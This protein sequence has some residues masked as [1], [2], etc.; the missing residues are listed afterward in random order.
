MMMKTKRKFDAFGKRE[1]RSAGPFVVFGNTNRR[2][3]IPPRSIPAGSIRI[4]PLLN[5]SRNSNVL[6]VNIRKCSSLRRKNISRCVAEPQLWPSWNFTSP[7]TSMSNHSCAPSVAGERIFVGIFRYEWS[8]GGRTLEK[9]SLFASATRRNGIRT[10]VS[11]CFNYLTRKLNKRSMPTWKNAA[12]R[13]NS[14]VDSIRNV[15]INARCVNSVPITR[16]SS[17]SISLA[18]IR[19]SR[20]RK[21]SF[22]KASRPNPTRCPRRATGTATRSFWSNLRWAL[23]ISTI[24]PKPKWKHRHFTIGRVWSSPMEVLFFLIQR[25]LSIR[26]S[27][28]MR[29]SIRTD[30]SIVRCAI[31]VI[32][33]D[34]T[35]SVITRR[36]TKRPRTKRRSAC[37]WVRNRSNVETRNSIGISAISNTCPSWMDWYPRPC[38]AHTTPRDWNRNERSKESTHPAKEPTT[39]TTTKLSIESMESTSGLPKHGQWIWPRTKLPLCWWSN[40]NDPTALRSRFMSSNPTTPW[41]SSTKT[42]R[43]RAKKSH[44]PFPSTW[45]NQSCERRVVSSRTAVRTVSTE[46]TGARIRCDTSEH[47][48]KSNRTRM[49]NTSWVAKKPNGPMRST[50]GPSVSLFQRKS[51]D[52]SPTFD[53][54]NG[55]ICKNPSGR[56]SKT[57]KVTNRSFSSAFDPMITSQHRPRH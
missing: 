3:T 48:T 28:R 23:I 51:W 10:W 22:T 38:P 11:K 53:I 30:C 17:N 18:I 39:T 33:G 27:R 54:F 24:R 2:S 50:N 16:N 9:S 40:H 7:R 20:R 6:I 42:D 25:I 34:T 21:C 36:C 14:T 31:E 8:S 47:D 49:D 35:S 37:R 15:V 44:R 43:R 55:E 29:T 4:L 19:T 13:R 57:N 1:R 32:A 45:I 56:K 5:A 46:P 12:W 52:V 26:T 41:S